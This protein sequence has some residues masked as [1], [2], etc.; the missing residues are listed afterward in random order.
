MKQLVVVLVLVAS[1]LAACASDSYYVYPSDYSNELEHVCLHVMQRG[2]RRF[3]V[4]DQHAVIPL[5]AA[6]S[7]VLPEVQTDLAPGGYFCGAFDDRQVPCS[8]GKTSNLNGT[9]CAFAR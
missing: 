3:M 5:Q 7:S 9:T 6:G 1:S 4:N 2:T 8:K